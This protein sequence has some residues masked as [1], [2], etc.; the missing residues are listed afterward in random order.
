M[1][2]DARTR[3]R[4]REGP[5]RKARPSLPEAPSGAWDA[6]GPGPPSGAGPFCLIR[7][8]QAFQ[9]AMSPMLMSLEASTGPI[10]W[11]R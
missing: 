10:F 5:G 8:A 1:T 11:G 9:T 3:D 4:G 6:E 7:S 2:A